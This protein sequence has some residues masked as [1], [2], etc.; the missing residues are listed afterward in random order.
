MDLLACRRAIRGLDRGGNRAGWRSHAR[1]RTDRKGVGDQPSLDFAWWTSEFLGEDGWI[2]VGDYES[3]V[4][5]DLNLG[6][7][8]RG[9]FES[10]ANDHSGLEIVIVSIPDN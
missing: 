6:P 7:Q 10:S 3:F 8:S 9:E 1:T 2:A 4:E 5:G